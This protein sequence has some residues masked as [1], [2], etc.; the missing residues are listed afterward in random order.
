M[1]QQPGRLLGAALGLALIT[2]LV[3]FVI[4]L[5]EV[6]G[7]LRGD[8]ALGYGLLFVVGGLLAVGL[9]GSFY[10]GLLTP[11]YTSVAG[12]GL[13]VLFV[14]A[15]ADVHAIGTLESLT[16][17]ELHAH[18]NGH[19]HNGHNDGHGHDN[20]HDHNGH[21][22]GHD[23]GHGHD[24]NGHDNGHDHN[25]HDNGH[26]HNGHDNGHDH[27]GDDHSHDDDSTAQVVIDHLRDDMLALG[28]KLAESTAA[29][30]FAAFAI[31]NRN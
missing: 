21:D 24:H 31:T 3:H 16:G 28:M 30:L 1:T 8:G 15:Y 7:A 9:V 25:G 17:A 29:V 20:S 5:F 6:G 19:D 10:T 27:N 11:I 22:N 4:G 12:V 14:L 13:M 2:G 23:D 18:D 26:D